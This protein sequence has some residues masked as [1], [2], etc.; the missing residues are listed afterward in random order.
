MLSR[1]VLEKMDLIDTTTLDSVMNRLEKVEHEI[2]VEIF[3]TTRAI[4]QRI[5]PITYD[6]S[7]EV[8]EV[9]Q[10]A[11]HFRKFELYFEH[12]DVTGGEGEIYEVDNDFELTVGQDLMTKI[13]PELRFGSIVS[14]EL[15]V[16]LM[17]REPKYVVRDGITFFEYLRLMKLATIV[18]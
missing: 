10:V 3:D 6:W 12:H 16:V 9:E 15:F 4:E 8:H 18:C 13:Q 7:D 14:R 11:Q 2:G 17:K 5:D 1:I